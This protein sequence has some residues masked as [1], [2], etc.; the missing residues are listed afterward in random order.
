[1][2]PPTPKTATA[3][4]AETDTAEH[5]YP[6]G[7]TPADRIHKMNVHPPPPPQST[8]NDWL[9]LFRLALACVGSLTVAMLYFETIPSDLINLTACLAMFTA[10]AAARVAFPEA[11][12]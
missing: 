5:Q 1:M 7:T 2:K 11:T 9:T 12:Q 10:Y 4:P 3:A 6:P 8:Q